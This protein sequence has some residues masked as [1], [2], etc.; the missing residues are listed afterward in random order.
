MN[1]YDATVGDEFLYRIINK[2]FYNPIMGQTI[3]SESYSDVI[4]V[5]IATNNGIN[6]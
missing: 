3:V 2:K 4:N 5:K 6:Y 1:L